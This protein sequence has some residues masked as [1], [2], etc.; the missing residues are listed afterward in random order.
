M[1]P[2]LGAKL[3][4]ITEQ[5]IMDI[6]AHKQQG[7]SVVG[8]YCLYGPTE[9][10]VA[11]DAI[12]LPLCGTRQDPIE[13]AE[14]TLPRNLCPLIKSSY[15][16][17]ATGTCPFFKFSDMIVADTTCDGKKKMFEIMGKIKHV[18]VLQLPQ[19]QNTELFL[20]PWITELEQLRQVIGDQAGIPITNERLSGAISLLNRERQAKKALMDVA[21]V[22]PSPISGIQMLEILFKTG[23]F[24]DKEKGIDLINEITE[25]CLKKAEKQD[26]PFTTDTPRILLTGV[27]VGLGSDKVVKIL[28]NSGAN[29]VAFENCSGYK[30]VFQVDEDKDPIKALAEQYLAIPCSVM[31]PNPGREDLLIRMVETFKV[32]GIVDLTWQAC[33]TYNVEAFQIRELAEQTCNLPYLHLETDYSESDTEQLRVRIE[34]FLEMI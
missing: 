8:Y 6:E 19:Q 32:D 27:P 10:A 29:V 9:L 22:K 30:Q 3:Q 14:Q 2:E 28:E 20:D 16:F 12:P 24:A 18:H 33:H 21:A 5:N 13:A 26:S 15:G 7:K 1:T 17:A 23:F 34:A 11:A 31:S 25:A 4:Q